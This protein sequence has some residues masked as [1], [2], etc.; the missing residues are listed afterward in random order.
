MNAYSNPLTEVYLL[1]LQ[2]ALQ[3]FVA[4]NKFLQ[5]DTSS[6]SSADEIISN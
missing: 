6:T 2:S 1:F 3:V 5:H 4:F